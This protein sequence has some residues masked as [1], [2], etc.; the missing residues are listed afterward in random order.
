MRR[1]KQR[2]EQILAAIG[3]GETDVGVL[4]ER[5]DVS[6]STVRRDLQR[7]SGEKAIMRTYGGAVLAP[8]VI[9][10]SLAERERTNHLAK[11]AIARAA[12]AHINDGETLILDGGS[13]VAALGQLLHE[14]RLQIVTNNIKLALTLGDAPEI[15]LIFLGG[16]IRSLGMTTC[17]PLAEEAMRSLTA[18]KLFTSADGLVAGRGLCEAS[19]EQISL[20]RVMMRQAEQTIVLADASKLGRAPQSA[21]ASLPE[22]WTL[23]T[24]SNA[25]EK[26]WRPF[27]AEGA[28]VVLAT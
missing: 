2:R 11:E 18:A 1:S 3:A 20:K 14:R 6:A 7:L 4:S 25:D 17:G 24:D 19:L 27:E 26:Q 16:S 28:T 5:F 21:W 15:T 23:I 10:E 12:L 8:P 22:R 9:E 13:T